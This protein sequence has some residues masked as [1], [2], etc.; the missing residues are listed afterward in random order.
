MCVTHC[1]CTVSVQCMAGL[2]I[3]GLVYQHITIR[4]K[5]Q[6]LHTWHI[7]HT[8]LSTTTA[9]LQRRAAFVTE[10]GYVMVSADYSQIELR[11]MAHFAQEPALCESL[12]DITQDPFRRLAAQWLHCSEHQVRGSF[13]NHS[14]PNRVD[15]HRT[16]QQLYEQYLC[17]T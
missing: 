5:L 12:R 13:T 16:A 11:L 9:W 10:E 17:T 4:T 7:L 2:L 14:R 3:R 6:L 1:R 15:Q 8:A